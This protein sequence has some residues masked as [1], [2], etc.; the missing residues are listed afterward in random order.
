MTTEN[1]K[2]KPLILIL[3]GP[4]GSGKGTQAVR[5][6]KEYQLPHIS[7][8]DIFR[9]HISKGTAIGKKV[10]EIIR[11]GS[12]VSDEMVLEMVRERF[13]NPDCA[14]GFVLDGFPRTLFQAEQLFAMISDQAYVLILCLD[15]PD[16]VIIERAVGRLVCKQCG[17]IYHRDASPPTHDG[18]CDK[19]GG[20]VYQRPDDQFEVVKAR[21]EVYHRQTLPLI[22]FYDERKLLTCFDGNQPRDLVYGELKNYIDE[23]YD[24][25]F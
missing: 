21:L 25:R 10:Q 8:G 14:Q 12:L 1:S 17:T 23:S 7:T 3:L 19:C 4:P 5:L 11:S 15:V 20:E 9:E 18:V 16:E 22:Q 2:K 6:S 24:K 13:S